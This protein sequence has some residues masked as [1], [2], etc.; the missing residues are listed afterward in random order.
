[1]GFGYYE[2]GG[3]E[4]QAKGRSW[5][6]AQILGPQD[7]FRESWANLGGSE[8]GPTGRRITEADDQ[9]RREVGVRLS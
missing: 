6:K 2:T 4:F 1:M 9:L 7:V 3:K 8:M 5:V